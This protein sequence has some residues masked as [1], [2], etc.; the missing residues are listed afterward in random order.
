MI[1]LYLISQPQSTWEKEDRFEGKTDTSITNLGKKQTK[2]ILE[3]LKTKQIDGIL[4]SSLTR[5]VQV[6][7]LFEKHFHFKP[8][9]DSRLNDIDRGA[10]T[11][12]FQEE[13]E[14]RYQ[15]SWEQWC[16]DLEK[17]QWPQGETFTEV[18]NRVSGFINSFKS[19]GL[20]DSFYIV[21]THDIIIKIIL[22]YIK[23]SDYSKMNSKYT[24]A[25]GSISLITVYPEKKV[26]NVNI[27]DYLGL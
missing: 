14:G 12:K 16:A 8:K 26:I 3:Y 18:T 19:S 9:R 11:G 5:S 6:A 13:V 22:S 2:Q 15:D 23:H 10:W 4:T 25:Q 24:L 21:V 1:Y 27:H 20:F 17:T 7:K